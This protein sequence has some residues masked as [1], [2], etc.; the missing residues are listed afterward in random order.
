MNHNYKP[1]FMPAGRLCTSLLLVLIL[2]VAAMPAAV[3]AEA[4]TIQSDHLELWED[5]QQALFTGSVHLVR[6]D[7][8]IFCDS[9]RAFYINGKEGGGIDHALAR[10]NVRIIHGDKQGKADTAMIDNRRQLVT[11]S[12]NAEMVQEGGR[13]TGETIVH[14]I[15][16]RTTEVSQGES[17]RV[18]LS[19]DDKKIAE[20]QAQK[21]VE[22]PGEG[23]H[24]TMP[25]AI[26]EEQK[27]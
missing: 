12:G 22:A 11:L 16:A 15:T 13:V 9:L 1:A 24:G 7:F 2:L 14:D 27:P 23:S 26:T 4:V 5:K 10:G 3:Q 21:G 20:D 17:G 19:I 6:E 18:T 8:E 25:D